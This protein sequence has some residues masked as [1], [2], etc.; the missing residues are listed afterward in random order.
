MEGSSPVNRSWG[1]RERG[2]AGGEV[3]R[4]GGVL[5]RSML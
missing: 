5:Q 3:G 2:Q 1:G 4:R